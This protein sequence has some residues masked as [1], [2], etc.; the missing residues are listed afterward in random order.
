MKFFKSEYVKPVNTGKEKQISHKLF[1]I[2]AS[3][4][5]LYLLWGKIAPI[6]AFGRVIYLER[7][8]TLNSGDLFIPEFYQ[9][10]D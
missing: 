3:H 9:L 7:N 10:Q 8:W 6:D 4:K 2:G 5:R 1:F